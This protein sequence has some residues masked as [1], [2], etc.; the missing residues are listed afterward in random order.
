[1]RELVPRASRLQ[2][3]AGIAPGDSAAFGKWSLKFILSNPTVSTVIPG[4]RNP[5][6]AEKNSSASD[7]QSLAKDR[8]EAVRKFW[9]EDS[10]LRELRT[11]L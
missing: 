9:R 11:G 5:Q 2:K 6:Q 10:W 7:G 8:V 3:L 1:M 4:A